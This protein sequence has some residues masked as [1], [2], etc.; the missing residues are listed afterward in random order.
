[1]NRQ[2]SDE[3][4]GFERSE[5]PSGGGQAPAEEPT[6]GKTS[7]YDVT[8]RRLIALRESLDFDDA[9]AR[10]AINRALDDLACFLVETRALGAKLDASGVAVD[11]WL[12][13]ALTAELSI[14]GAA[15]LRISTLEGERDAAFAEIGRLRGDEETWNLSCSTFTRKLDEARAAQQQEE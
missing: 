7:H 5:A 8:V 3:L 13:R 12:Y 4:H 9:S 6:D 14:E 11:K 2:E 10:G 15:R 1:V